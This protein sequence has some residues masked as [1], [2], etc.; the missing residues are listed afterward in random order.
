MFR[1]VLIAEDH[2]IANISVQKTLE[3]LGISGAKYVYYCDDAFSWVSNALRTG[4]P[5]DL[6]ITDLYFEEDHY[7]QQL[8]DG[9]QLIRAVKH[10]QPSLKVIVFSAESRPAVVN[11]LF[12]S[13]SIDGYVRKA[14]RDAQHL[15][16]ALQAVYGQKTYLSPD[17]KQQVSDKNAHE[18]T[19]FDITIITLL[20]QGILQKDIPYYLRQKNI[21][22]SGLSSV[23][24]RL[25]LMKDVLGFSKNEQL[26]AYSKDIGVI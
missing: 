26:I 25:N 19:H 23:E 22:P 4:E 17:V 8:A 12:K 18:F 1:K 3:A 20:S 14:R 15:K 24:K 21:R 9:D 10:L 13:H 2:E 5:Y 6:L 7:E 16:E 11:R